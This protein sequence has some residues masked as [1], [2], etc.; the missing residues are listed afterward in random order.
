[1]AFGAFVRKHGMFF[2]MILIFIAMAFLTHWW[3]GTW[4]FLSPE[5]LSNL[6][7]QVTV[8]GILALG[9][10]FVILIGGIDLSVGSILAVCAVVLALLSDPTNVA[11]V[12]PASGYRSL[13]QFLAHPFT[14]IL[15]ALAAGILLGAWNGLLVSRGKVLPFIV[16]LATLTI[17]RGLAYLASGSQSLRVKASIFKVLGL[18]SLDR[19]CYEIWY[20][21]A[22]LPREAVAA[23]AKKGIPKGDQVRV[24]VESLSLPDKLASGLPNPGKIL[25]GSTFV[26]GFTVVFLLVA[27]LAWAG[28][29]LRRRERLEKNGVPVPPKE[30][31]MTQ[32]VVGA[33]VF[34]LLGIVFASHQGIPIMVLLFAALALG[35]SFLLNRTVFGRHLYAIGGNREA[36]YLAGVRVEKCTFIVFVLMG[37]LCAVSGIVATSRAQAA[38]PATQGVLAEL[39]AIAAVVVGGTSLMG[40]VGTIGGTIIGVLIIGIVVN[41][42]ILMALPNPVQLIFKGLLIVAAVLIDMRTKRRSSAG[43]M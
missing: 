21:I 31:T 33:V 39:E 7:E 28:L 37:L 14:A 30:E 9:M 40:G 5:N 10:T 29:V 15:F 13:L 42:M 27:F 11:Q 8:N 22:G 1:M 32:L 4:A 17:G 34:L 25:P 16:T 36:A 6:S 12:V 41:G 43:M 2:S 24:F 20:G 26:P 38:T 3:T 35:A 19:L 18:Y 23:M